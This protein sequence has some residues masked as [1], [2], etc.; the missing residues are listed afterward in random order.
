MCVREVLNLFPD[1]TNSLILVFSQTLFK[2]DRWTVTSVYQ[3]IRISVTLAHFCCNEKLNVKQELHFYSTLNASHQSI[4]CAHLFIFFVVTF[5][6]ALWICSPVN[7]DFVGVYALP[8]VLW[9]FLQWCLFFQ[10]FSLMAGPV[11]LTLRGFGS[12]NVCLCN[13]SLSSGPFFITG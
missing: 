3:F 7:F 6:C 5:L 11:N 2:W 12:E 1:S 10:Y 4:C 8:A 13:D 9:S